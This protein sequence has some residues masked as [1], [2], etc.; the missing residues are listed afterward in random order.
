MKASA[1]SSIYGVQNDYGFQ[2]LYGIPKQGQT[3]EEVEQLLLDQLELLKQGQF[4]DWII[5][6]IITD[7]KQSRKAGLERNG[8]RVSWMRMPEKI[9]VSFTAR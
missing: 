6:A 5:P 2:Y 7:F 4:E 3:L 9:P 1:S 8:S